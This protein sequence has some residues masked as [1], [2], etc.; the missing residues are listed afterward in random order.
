M[1]GSDNSTSLSSLLLVPT[2]KLISYWLVP[3]FDRYRISWCS[4]VNTT[5]KVGK[6]KTFVIIRLHRDFSRGPLKYY[7]P[8]PTWLWFPPHYPIQIVSMSC[9]FPLSFYSARQHEF[10]WFVWFSQKNKAAKKMMDALQAWFYTG[11]YYQKKDKYHKRA[12]KFPYLSCLHKA[13]W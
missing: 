1:L 12:E 7:V 5:E 8:V 10:A 3:K 4:C 13:Y 2:R 6:R 11:N 9:F